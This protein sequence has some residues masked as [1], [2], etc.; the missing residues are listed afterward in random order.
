VRSLLCVIGRHEWQV[1][2]DEVGRARLRFADGRAVITFDI[3]ALG[4]APALIEVPH[5][6]SLDRVVAFI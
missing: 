2:H 1:K 6:R 5:R 3:T 4:Q